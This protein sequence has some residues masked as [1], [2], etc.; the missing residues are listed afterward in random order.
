MS[1]VAPNAARPIDKFLALHEEATRRTRRPMLRHELVSLAKG[2][3]IPYD[4]ACAF[5][6]WIEVR[7]GVFGTD[8]SPRDAATVAAWLA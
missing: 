3:G 2:Y 4:V 6:A 1:N 8:V 7:E 5:S